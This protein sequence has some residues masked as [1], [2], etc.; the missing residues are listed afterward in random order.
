MSGVLRLPTTKLGRMLPPLMPQPRRMPTRRK[1][2]LS[3]ATL[4]F[5]TNN[6]TEQDQKAAADARAKQNAAAAA[7]MNQMQAK[8][9]TAGADQ[10]AAD[11]K[12]QQDAQKKKDEQKAK[13]QAAADKKVRRL[14]ILFIVTTY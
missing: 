6:L 8:N 7:M 13:E 12:A 9:G 11:A 4:K 14:A 2:C 5:P 3:I 10:A 1:V